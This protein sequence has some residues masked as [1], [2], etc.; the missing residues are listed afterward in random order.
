MVLKD[1]NPVY[2]TDRE[3]AIMAWMSDDLDQTTIFSLCIA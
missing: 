2:L 3:A 1:G